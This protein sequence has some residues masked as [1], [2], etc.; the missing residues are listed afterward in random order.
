MEERKRRRGHQLSFLYL[1]RKH[2]QTEGRL[3]GDHYGM[4]SRLLG[5]EEAEEE[6]E[7]E[8]EVEAGGAFPASPQ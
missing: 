1:S 6:E 4:P 2:F 3:Y 8:G 5:E 7:E